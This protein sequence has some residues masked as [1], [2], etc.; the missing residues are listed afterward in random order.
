MKEA[1]LMVVV[2]DQAVSSLEPYAGEMAAVIGPEV[3]RPRVYLIYA[4]LSVLVPA[5]CPPVAD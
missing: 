5:Q 2:R 1:I 4:S 3:T